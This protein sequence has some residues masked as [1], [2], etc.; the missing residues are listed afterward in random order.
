MLI[1]TL[2]VTILVRLRCARDS[3]RETQMERRRYIAEFAACL[4]KMLGRR[5]Y[6]QC[7][8]AAL[9]GARPSRIL[10]Q[11]TV[12]AP[13][14]EVPYAMVVANRSAGGHRRVRARD[15][16]AAARLDRAVSVSTAAEYG[17][18]DRR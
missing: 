10:R 1:V 9:T 15:V 2:L 18:G 14:S 6:P 13:A 4:P 11:T 7:G 17:R 3:H 5:Y 8:P 16:P 12:G